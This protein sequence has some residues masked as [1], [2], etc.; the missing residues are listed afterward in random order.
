MEWPVVPARRPQ[1]VRDWLCHILHLSCLCYWLGAFQKAVGLGSSVSSF[2][3][4]QELSLWWASSKLLSEALFILC[5][6]LLSWQWSM[7]QWPSPYPRWVSVL[8]CQT[9]LIMPENWFSA[10]Y[11]AS[12]SLDVP[13]TESFSHLQIEVWFKQIFQ[14]SVICFPDKVSKTPLPIFHCEFQPIFSHWWIDLGMQISPPWSQ[15]GSWNP[16]SNPD[17]LRLLSLCHSKCPAILIR[18][19][20]VEQGIMFSLFTFSLS[21]L[22][23]KCWCAS[24]P[25]SAWLLFT[26]CLILIQMLQL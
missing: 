5:W 21:A 2:L 26:F 18:V 17:M 8:A 10:Y 6:I 7:L 3:P 4:L 23:D 13:L 9:P 24:L 1:T 25:T 11:I 22:T 19:L 20:S 14:P 16:R 15:A 12:Q